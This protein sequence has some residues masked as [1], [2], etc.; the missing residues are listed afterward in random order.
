MMAM[1]AVLPAA[2]EIVHPAIGV[3]QGADGIT[4]PKDGGNH[5]AV[6][7]AGV[8]FKLAWQIAR[9]I[10]GSNR[11]DQAMRDFLLDA[12]CLAALG[13]IADVV[14]LVG[15][16]RVLATF[17]LRALPKTRRAGLRALID[18]AGLAGEKLDAFHV[19]FMLAPR[20]N[21]CGRMGHAAL[22]V[23]MLTDAPEDRCI[24]IAEY[25]AQQNAARQKVEREIA[26]QAIEMA[27]N[28]GMDAPAVRAIVLASDQWHGGV[29]GIVASRLVERFGKPAMLIAING[30]G[31][32]QGSGR[33]IAGFDIEQALSACSEHLQAHGGH[34]MACGLR[35]AAGK[36]DAFRGAMV[37]YAATRVSD[38]QLSPHLRIDAHATLGAL[39]GNLVGHLQRMAPFGQG[40]PPPMVAIRDCQLLGQPRRIGK[41]SQTASLLLRQNGVSMRAVGFGMGDLADALVGVNRIDVAGEPTLN[42]F[43][44]N[45]SVEL[46][47]K[48]V[49]WE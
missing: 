29:I 4:G 13:T 25:L 35:I 45:T 42:T 14:P 22:A 19:G 2:C 47:L 26:Q 21:A 6:S 23:E 39:D 9:E 20:I 38:E 41:T 15:E 16:N 43:N 37:E 18:S 11:V 10:C 28:M 17:G 49:K 40:N 3:G 44:G 30:D 7:G 27:V 31:C 1:P 5:S 46:R 33:S 8:A 48:D 24:K 12:T 36:I 34:A 32:G